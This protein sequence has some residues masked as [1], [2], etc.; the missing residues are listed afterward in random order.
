VVSARRRAEQSRLEEGKAF[1]RA[2]MAVLHDR[3]GGRANVRPDGG[4]PCRRMHEVSRDSSLWRELGNFL[5][6]ADPPQANNRVFRRH[7]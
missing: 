7:C 2:R 5:Y 1:L 3:S 4:L 6:V